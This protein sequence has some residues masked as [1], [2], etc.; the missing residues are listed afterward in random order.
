[1]VVPKIGTQFVLKKIADEVLASPAK[2]EEAAAAETVQP[3]AV[4]PAPVA[5]PERD[6]MDGQPVKDEEGVV[7]GR[8]RRVRSIAV[9][10][11]SDN[12]GALEADLESCVLDDE[13]QCFLVRDEKDRLTGLI[14]APHPDRMPK[15]TGALR[16]DD[17]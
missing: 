14:Y 16:A 2:P 17:I 10:V 9:Y 5:P 12:F 11:V 1:M 4:A 13:S 15:S 6:E 8:A 3:Q 7:I